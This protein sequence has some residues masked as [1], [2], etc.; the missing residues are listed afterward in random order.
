MR[1]SAGLCP[2]P[3]WRDY[4]A[5]QTSWIW[6]RGKG[7]G[8]Q[9]GEWIRRKGGGYGNSRRERKGMRRREE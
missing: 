8:G 9:G 2:H 6:G 1:L 4:S 5:A 7:R 3:L